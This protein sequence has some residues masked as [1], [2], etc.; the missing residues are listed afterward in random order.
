MSPTGILGTST[1][2]VIGLGS[3]DS[4]AAPI[5]FFDYTAPAGGAILAS[6]KS[7]LVCILALT[8][9]TGCSRRAQL[10][11]VPE[12]LYNGTKLSAWLNQLQESDSGAL[13][14]TD[15]A[16][17]AIR[18]LGPSA[19]PW[20]TAELIAVE[21]QAAHLRHYAGQGGSTAYDRNDAAL[22]A[23]LVL[24]PVAAPAVT[25]IAPIFQVLDNYSNARYC[26]ISALWAIGPEAVP[27]LLAGLKH[28]DGTT[29]EKSAQALGAI[30]PPATDAVPA[31]LA[32]LKDPEAKVRAAG[33]QALGGIHADPETVVPALLQ[34]FRSA[35]AFV[36]NP[37]P[38]PCVVNDRSG[39]A[40]VAL[41]KPGMVSP[42]LNEDSLLR[43][44]VA[45]AEALG[46]YGPGAKEALPE[47]IAYQQQPSPTDPQKEITYRNVRAAIREALPLIA[48]P[49]KA[50]KR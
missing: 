25:N 47:L 32:L 40:R 14:L 46:K 8:L 29:R 36:A 17:D 13:I 20:L 6:M 10:K 44:Q 18:N 33:A 15:A 28:P 7:A 5:G 9:A 39:K 19:L 34:L 35:P 45:A 4:Q 22:R 3:I 48:G 16:K 2:Q 23:F 50:P 42:A 27:A 24:G 37:Q 43:I 21:S 26:A 41:M 12:P 31:L 30:Q 11:S 38:R 49:A 1:G